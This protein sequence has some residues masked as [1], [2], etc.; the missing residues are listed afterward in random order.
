MGGGHRH[1]GPDALFVHGHSAVHRLAPEAKIVATAAYVGAVVATPRAAFWAFGV[2]AALVLAAA[3]AA[4]LP[5]L[6]LARRL[7]IE[8]PF[9]A[10][11]VFLPLAGSGPDVVVAGLPLSQA[12]L[13]AA[14]NVVAKATLG[15]L[16]SIVLASTT[17]VADLL[18]GLDRLHVPR[19]LTAIAG[20]MVRYLAIISGEAQR[21]HV[22]RQSRGYD[23]RWLGQAR[24]WAAGAGTLFVRS[25]ERGERV[26]LAMASRGYTGT[27]PRLDD[28]AGRRAAAAQWAAAASVPLGAWIVALAAL[29][30][31]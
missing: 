27:M 28:P 11:A 22:A 6:L 18:R 29:G 16:A 8:A 17:P 1:G 25:Y 10:F 21:M 30:S 7:R 13:W 19:V 23:P 4:G 9:V 31:W 5:P 20:F 3:T 15:T 12:G 14:W 2:H 26:Y 24:A